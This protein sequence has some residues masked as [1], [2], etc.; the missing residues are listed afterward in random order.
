MPKIAVYERGHKDSDEMVSISWNDPE[1]TQ[2]KSGNPFSYF[3]NPKD[4][5]KKCGDSNRVVNPIP[6]NLKVQRTSFREKFQKN[7]ERDPLKQYRRAS[8]KF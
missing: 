3:D 1:P 8:G 4:H 5:D 6:D 2:G 7:P